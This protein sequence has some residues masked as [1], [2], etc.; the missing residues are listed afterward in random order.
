M[1]CR[2]KIY[3][4]MVVGCFIFLLVLNLI[5]VGVI[6]WSCFKKDPIGGQHPAHADA[7]QKARAG[8]VVVLLGQ[9]QAGAAAGTLSPGVGAGHG[10]ASITV[11]NV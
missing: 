1:I 7:E 2:D 10:R 3:V 11:L 6:I 4:Q 9:Q 8:T 5:G